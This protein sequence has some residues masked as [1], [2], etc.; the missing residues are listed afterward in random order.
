MHSLSPS[1]RPIAATRPRNCRQN[2]QSRHR[3]GGIHRFSPPRPESLIWFRSLKNEWG[4]CTQGLTKFRTVSKPL[5]SYNTMVFIFPRH[6]VPAG[7][8]VTYAEPYR[9]RMTDGV[10]TVSMLTKTSTLLLLVALTPSSTSIVFSLMPTLV[11]AT[12]PAI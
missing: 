2:V 12:S 5:S 6:Q 10:K 4:R 11:P 3:Q 9:I 7:H 8:K 1:T